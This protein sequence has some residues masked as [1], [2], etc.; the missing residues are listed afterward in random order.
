MQVLESTSL[1][2]SMFFID[3]FRICYRA[4]ALESST[5][6]SKRKSL[7]SDVTRFSDRDWASYKNRFYPLNKLLHRSTDS[8]AT[9]GLT[10]SGSPQP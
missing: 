10:V 7:N 1:K 8:E 2:L 9:S 5:T 6:E 3:M 4:I